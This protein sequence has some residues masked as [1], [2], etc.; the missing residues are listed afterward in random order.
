M[1]WLGSEFIL[2]PAEAILVVLIEPN[3]FTNDRI[4]DDEYLFDVL[5]NCLNFFFFLAILA[6]IKLG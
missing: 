2:E 1:R 3:D 6:P 5:P 4:I